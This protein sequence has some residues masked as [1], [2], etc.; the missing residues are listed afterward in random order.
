MKCEFCHNEFS[1]KQNV[2][3]HQ[4][5]AKYCLKIQG[6]QDIKTHKC[7]GCR[8]EYSTIDS[9]KRHSSRCKGSEIANL[10]KIIQEFREENKEIKKENQML[11]LELEKSQQRYAELSLT[12]VKRP[13]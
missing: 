12:A 1:N 9:Y 13:R 6:K 7:E 3:A 5:K 4:R 2:N 11:Q 8:K 10:H